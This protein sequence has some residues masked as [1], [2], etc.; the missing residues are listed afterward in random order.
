MHKWKTLA[1][2]ELKSYRYL[3]DS[4]CNLQKILKEVDEI[5]AGRGYSMI[6]SPKAQSRNSA[7]DY[8]VM[9]VHKKELVQRQINV[10]QD[11]L[12]R[13]DDTLKRLTEDEHKILQLA[14]IDRKRNYIFRITEQFYVGQTQAYKYIS[15]ALENYILIAYGVTEEQINEQREQQEQQPKNTDTV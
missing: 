1:K 3:E 14:Y 12:Q 9:L 5:A 15:K 2:S 6:L 8:F 4:I 11:I 13:V 10:C 7:E